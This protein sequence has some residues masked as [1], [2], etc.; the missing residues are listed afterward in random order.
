MDCNESNDSTSDNQKSN[1]GN[2]DGN[3]PNLGSNSSDCPEI[4]SNTYDKPQIPLPAEAIERELS[5]PSDSSVW[6][7]IPFDSKLG[8]ESGVAFYLKATGVIPETIP[9]SSPFLD[10]FQEGKPP[11]HL[12]RR[13]VIFG[14]EQIL[15]TSLQ[16]RHIFS[17]CCYI[18]KTAAD[19]TN[20]ELVDLISK[21]TNETF[22]EA[23]LSRCVRSGEAIVKHEEARKIWDREVLNA[24]M[25]LSDEMRKEIF[26]SGRVNGKVCIYTGS[27]K[28]II[29]EIKAFKTGKPRSDS[30][31]LSEIAARYIEVINATSK[32]I[33]MNDESKVED[34]HGIVFEPLKA[35]AKLLCEFIEN[36]EKPAL[37][38]AI[39]KRT[40]L[41]NA[42]DL[43][44]SSEVQDADIDRKS[45]GLPLK[46]DIGITCQHIIYLVP[47]I[48]EKVRR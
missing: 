23:Y 13:A 6:K 24:T 20:A 5:E 36:H 2:G 4:T 26:K 11:M 8:T 16:H 30:T 21:A 39:K 43:V 44:L 28:D 38:A 15:S 22:S 25:S 46:T 45:E 10:A 1:F 40:G 7:P 19:I 14:M 32:I 35:I 18:Y 42:F 27:R 47:L 33:Q 41:K 29:A 9:K 12:D 17:V 48:S 3:N 37:D 31:P 34:E